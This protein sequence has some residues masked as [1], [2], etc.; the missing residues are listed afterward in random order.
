MRNR[1]SSGAAAVA[2][3]GALAVPADAAD[4]HV[5]INIGV[6]PPI[7]FES[8][9]QLVVVPEAPQVLYAP[10]APV[11]FFSYGGQFY[12]VHQGQWFVAGAERGPWSYVERGHVP[13]EVLAVPARYYDGRGHHGKHDKHR[14]K[15][16]HRDHGHDDHHG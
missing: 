15:H 14:G 6:P 7:V 1:I 8:P 3:L 9:P 13:H 11:G 12:R 10:A 16:H 2:L 4:V 5:G